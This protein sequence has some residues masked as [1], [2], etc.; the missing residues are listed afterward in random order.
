VTLNVPAPTLTF[1]LPDYANKR[2]VNVTARPSDPGGTGIAGYYFSE[3]GTP[4]AV[5]A[6]GWQLAPTPFT[7]SAGDGVKT[8]YAWA[9]DRNRSLSARVSDTTR[10]D[11]TAPTAT[12]TAPATT[13]AATLT[14]TVGGGDGTGSGITRYALVLGTTAPA[15]RSAD[16][17]AS[18]SASVIL[19]VGSNTVS[20][21]TRD[22]AGNVSAAATRTVVY[23]P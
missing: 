2:A 5:D 8:V 4:P 18:A 1:A 9:K 21:F 14:A 15:A 23:T 12:L 3:N 20:A 10:L 11:T 13:S 6:A 17:V 22:A 19:N 7:L 16:W